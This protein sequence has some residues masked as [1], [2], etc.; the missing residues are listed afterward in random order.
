MDLKQFAKAC[1]CS[2]FKHADPNLHGGN[3]G[4]KYAGTQSSGFSTENEAIKDWMVSMFDGKTI[5]AIKALA[6]QPKS[7]T[8]DATHSD[9]EAMR[10]SLVETINK[11]GV[12]KFARILVEE[13]P[14]SPKPEAAKEVVKPT[15]QN[16]VS[17]ADLIEELKKADPEA[18]VVVVGN[19]CDGGL[20]DV[21]PFEERQ[22]VLKAHIQSWVGPHA[23]ATDY[24][25]RK[26]HN[27][28][29]IY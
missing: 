20:N 4:Y 10:D 13:E 5:T 2:V 22:I 26:R 24:P 21:G 11:F 16:Y 17:V 7:A 23:L 8:G 3:F 25:K 9:C 19:G 18:R 12:G 6:K 1:G 14:V 15:K 29:I 28:F 27:A